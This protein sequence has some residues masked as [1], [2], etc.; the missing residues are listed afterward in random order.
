MTLEIKISYTENLPN[1]LL[2]ARN[3]LVFSKPF[4]ALLFS[5]YMVRLGM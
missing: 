3:V 1:M 2:N 4:N 5:N